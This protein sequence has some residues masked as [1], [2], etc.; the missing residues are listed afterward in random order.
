MQIRSELREK[1][2]NNL[3]LR[4]GINTQE[5]GS[6]AVTIVDLLIDELMYF[7]Q[8]LIRV[9]DQ[10]YLSTSSGIFTELIAELV[11][12]QRLEGESD[13]SLKQRASQSV[14]IHAGGNLVAIQQAIMNTQGVASF[15]I[16]RYGMG[17]GSFTVY[18]YPQAGA[19]QTGIL[20]RVRQNL[21]RVVAEG[22]RFEVKLPVEQRIDLAI[23]LQFK[24]GLSITQ[25]DSIKGTAKQ[26]IATYINSLGKDEG[27]YI[28]EIIQ[29]V[30]EINLNILDMGIQEF[31][32]DDVK[33]TPHNWFPDADSRFVSGTITII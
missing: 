31:K 11:N 6:I 8:E 22:I 17:T 5:E 3:A 2:L 7:N 25:K 16:K 4:T 28:N 19:N 18:V 26:A 23:I 30:M 9:R 1:I 10:A 33:Y 21:S 20:S 24:E 29:R 32:V 15:D 12:I 27:L 13:S 14:Y